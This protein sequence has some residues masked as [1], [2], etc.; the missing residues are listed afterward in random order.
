MHVNIHINEKDNETQVLH[1]RPLEADQPGVIFFFFWL[2]VKKLKNN[3]NPPLFKLL[4]NV[5]FG[6]VCISYARIE[7]N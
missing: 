2:I 3:H 4:N 6:L 5:V 1:Y 7:S